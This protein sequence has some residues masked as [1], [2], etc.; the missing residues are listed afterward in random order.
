MNKLE[1]SPQKEGKNVQKEGMIQP[2]ILYI[3]F[4]VYDYL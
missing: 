1:K 2:N 4:Y 3:A